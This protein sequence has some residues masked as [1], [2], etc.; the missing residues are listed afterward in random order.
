MSNRQRLNRRELLLGLLSSAVGCNVSKPDHGF[1]G[2]MGRFTDKAQAGLFLPER[3]A[4]ATPSSAITVERD[5]PAYKIGG[6]YP[7][8]PANWALEVSGAVAR[9]HPFTLDELLRLPRAEMRVR[10]H[11]VEGWSAVASWHGV[12]VSD[13]AKLVGADPD[14]N[15]VEFV[16]FEPIPS[17]VLEEPGEA[18]SKLPPGM[19]TLETKATTYTSSWDRA[20]ALHAQTLL[21]FGMNGQPLDRFHGG[22]VRLYSATK[23]GYKMVKWLSAVRFRFQPTGGYWEEQ[24]YEWFAGV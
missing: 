19:P 4:P 13:V 1:F 23:L 5:F 21:A 17:R 24:G 3:M 18:H 6:D 7:Q 16:S 11:C 14:A 8:V 12:R 20:S 15:Y 10:H 22:P 2:E 9:P